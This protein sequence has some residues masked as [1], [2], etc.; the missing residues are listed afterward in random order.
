MHLRGVNSKKEGRKNFL[1]RKR[2][3]NKRI[4]RNQFREEKRPSK[5]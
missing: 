3:N 5:K 4:K 2:D 1:C